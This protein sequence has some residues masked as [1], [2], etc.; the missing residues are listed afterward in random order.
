MIL[1]LRLFERK[2][3]SG[4]APTHG[5][6]PSRKSTP[7]L[8]AIRRHL[9]FGHAEVARFPHHVAAERSSGDVA[10]TRDEVEDDVEPDWPVDAGDDEHPLEQLLHRLDALAHGVRIRAEPGESALLL[11]HDGHCYSPVPGLTSRSVSV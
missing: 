1:R 6:R 9:P 8:P 4:I 3:K 5:I 7:T 10:D 2:K 11:V